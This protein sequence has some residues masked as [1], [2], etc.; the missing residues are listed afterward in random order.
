M[1]NRQKLLIEN[2]IRLKVKKMMNESTHENVQQFSTT[3][4]ELDGLLRLLIK[5]PHIKEEPE[6]KTACFE[7]CKAFLKVDN[8][9]KK[10]IGI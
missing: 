5:N 4:V 2:Y 10:I 7:L 1:T 3:M 9:N 6:L 8:I